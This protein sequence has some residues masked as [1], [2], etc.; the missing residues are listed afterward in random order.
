[1]INLALTMGQG[2][3][4]P[5]FYP[6]GPGGIA[7]VRPGISQVRIPPNFGFFQAIFV[8]TSFSDTDKIS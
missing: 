2:L 4:P 6:T 5:P 7:L 3:L 8:L 1:M